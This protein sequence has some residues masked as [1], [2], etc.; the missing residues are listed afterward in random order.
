[1]AGRAQRPALR[2]AAASPA[3]TRAVRLRLVPRPVPH[4]PA[5][6]RWPRSFTCS[7]S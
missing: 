5:A 7:C 2:F 3:L 1:V 4:R 6:R